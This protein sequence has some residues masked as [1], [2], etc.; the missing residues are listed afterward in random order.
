MR[1]LFA[2]LAVAAIV[3]FTLPAQAGQCPLDMKKPHVAPQRYLLRLPCRPL[4][5][6]VALIVVAAGFQVGAELSPPAHALLGG[7]FALYLA[8][9]V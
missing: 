7:D 6:C 1:K 3:G 9:N 2:A 8:N 5:G 4:T